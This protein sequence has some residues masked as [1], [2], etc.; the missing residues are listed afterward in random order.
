M[1]NSGNL[2]SFLESYRAAVNAHQWDELQRYYSPSVR[3]NDVQMDPAS[4][5]GGLTDVVAAFPDWNWEARHTAF[6][7][8]LAMVHF[9]DTGTHKGPFEGIEPTGRKIT[10][11]E[12]ASYRVVDG[13]ITEMWVTV[14]MSSLMQQLTKP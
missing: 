12:F 1:A 6:D 2:R 9:R 5:V 11:Q 3:L 10:V 4:L 8:D 14:D 7:G 13:K